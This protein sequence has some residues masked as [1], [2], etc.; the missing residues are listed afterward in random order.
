MENY[1]HLL[2]EIET[3]GM[4]NTRGNVT[5]KRDL[6]KSLDAKLTLKPLSGGI[7]LSRISNYTDINDEYRG[8]IQQF[9]LI[10]MCVG[11]GV[12]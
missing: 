2:T 7:H 10:L 8:E 1:P 12:G 6:K 11:S 4:K 3:T 5:I 9:Y